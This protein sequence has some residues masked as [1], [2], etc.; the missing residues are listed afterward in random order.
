MMEWIEVCDR[1][2]HKKLIHGKMYKVRLHNDHELDAK[3][4]V[5]QGGEEV[6]FILPVSG[7][8]VSVT[9]FLG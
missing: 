3:F 8:E 7:R 4:N 6:A 9:H 2:T 1:I 5:Y